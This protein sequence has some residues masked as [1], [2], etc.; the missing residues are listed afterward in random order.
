[1]SF[2]PRSDPAPLGGAAAVVGD[3]RDV[4]DRG[5]FE[6]RGLERAD[7]LLAT[8]A[9][10]LDE[11]L[12]LTHS[13]LHRATGRAIGRERRCVRRALPGALEAGD[14]GGAPADHGATEVGDR[15]DRV[16]ERRLDVDVPLGDVLPFAAALLDR[17][18]AFGHGCVWSLG[19]LLPP[20]AD[21][22]LRSAPLTGVGL[23]SLAP[24]GQVAPVTHPPIGADLDQALDVER[25]LPPQVALDLVATIDE[26]TQAVDLLLG[27]VPDA[28]VRVH[29]GL[30][31][32]L[33]R[34]RQADPE[35]VGEGDLDPLLA[36]DVDA[37]NACH[38]L[39]LPLLVLRVG[40][41]DHHGAMA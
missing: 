10:S 14:A 20:D 35:D 2:L 1:M 40:A 11:D 26:L 12:D 32:D 37:G 8:G 23:R 36:G 25:N 41:D 15:D 4:G 21:G 17:L 33:L 6:A 18:L 28:R 30:R 38:R 29:V 22:L 16:V 24:D 39:P 27:E 13:V 3:R 31:E 5:D 7:R 34:G 9:R 19:L